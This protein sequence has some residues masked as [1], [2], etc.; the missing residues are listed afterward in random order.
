MEDLSIGL[1]PIETQHA[2]GWVRIP[3]WTNYSQSLTGLLAL[4]WE[5]RW[6]EPP[7]FRMTT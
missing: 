4:A 7:S 3:T 5:C 6:G 2:L 1:T